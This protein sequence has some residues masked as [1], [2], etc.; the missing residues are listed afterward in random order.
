MKKLLATLALLLMFTSPAIA[1][2]Y[3]DG[4]DDG[5]TGQTNWCDD[6]DENCED[7]Y[8]DGQRFKQNN[9]Y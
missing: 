7:G 9:S 8:E 2:S 5:S 6:G 1:D 4:Y 3:D